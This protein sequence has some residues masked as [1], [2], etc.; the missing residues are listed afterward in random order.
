MSYR[1]INLCGNR[2]H[3][4]GLNG[5]CRGYSVSRLLRS[6]EMLTRHLQN[7]VSERGVRIIPSTPCEHSVVFLTTLCSAQGVMIALYK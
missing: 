4:V 5:N 1:S 7:L 6:A 2:G 3:F